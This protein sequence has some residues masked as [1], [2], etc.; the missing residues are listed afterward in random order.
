M[1]II[2]DCNYVSYVSAFSFSK[3]LSYKSG[4]TEVIFGF[5][6][7]IIGTMLKFESTEVIFCWDSKSNKRK[8]L[9]PEYKANRRKNLTDEEKES[10]NLVYL[11][12]DEIRK[13]VLPE[14]GFSNVFMLE[15]YE[16]DDLIANILQTEKF[17][18]TIVIASDND[19]LQLLDFCSIYNISKKQTINKTIFN[20]DYGI[21]PKEWVQV[22]AIAGCNTDNIKGVIGVGEKKAIAFLKGELKGKSLENIKNSKEIIDRNM[23]LVKLPF[24]GCPTLK[25]RKNDLSIEKFKTICKEYGFESL[26][27]QKAISDWSKIIS[28]IV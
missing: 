24:E 7:N 19:L 22:K 28:R 15:G 10:F 6:K 8:N 13:I 14:I 2:F 21:E 11:Q 20:R 18:K 25:L 16:S 1:K 17:D 9:L 4:R 3:G 23:R 27:T 12:F 5:L 26:L